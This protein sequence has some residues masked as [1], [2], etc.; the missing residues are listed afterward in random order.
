[1]NDSSSRENGG[2][3]PATPPRVCRHSAAQGSWIRV[4]RQQPCPICQ[5]PDNCQVSEDGGAVWCGRVAEGSARENNGG[6]YLHWLDGERAD[7]VPPPR[8]QRDAEPVTRDWPK[9]AQRLTQH[10]EQARE[11]LAAQLGVS[12]ES[13]VQLHVGWNSFNAFWSFPERNGDGA[14]IGV[15]ARYTSS[16]KKR[17][18]GSCAGLTHAEQWDTGDGPILLVEG[19]TDTAALLTL[20]LTVVGRPS[21]SGGVEFLLDLLEH[22]HPDR[23]IIVIGER[24]EKDDGRWPGRDGAIRTATRLAEELQRPVAWS[25]PPDHAKDSRAWLQAMAGVPTERRAE[26][27]LSGLDPKVIRPPLT[28]PPIEVIGPVVDI[29][30]WREQML[31][32]RLQSLKRPGIYLDASSTGAGKSRVDF[33]AI[34]HLCGKESAA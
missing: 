22:V 20:E 10:A 31:E 34:L 26:L 15:S 18:S 1:M 12:V 7:P 28:L 2:D 25:L 23:E 30:D 32:A 8:K 29:G 16:K 6:Q 5:K 13:L 27:F 4:S 3:A 17:L 9:Y 11:R 14:I 19:G 21:N 33:E 24:D